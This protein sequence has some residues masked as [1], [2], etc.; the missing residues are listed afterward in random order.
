MLE[1]NAFQEVREKVY[2]D[3]VE[4]VIEAS[5]VIETDEIDPEA[6]RDAFY[7]LD[8]HGFDFSEAVIIINE[9]EYEQIHGVPVKEYKILPENTAIIIHPNSIDPSPPEIV[10]PGIIV[11]PGGIVTLK[12]DET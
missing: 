6:F 2:R 7:E 8:N 12:K 5:T 3:F 11:Y 4:E 9:S 1:N 10:K